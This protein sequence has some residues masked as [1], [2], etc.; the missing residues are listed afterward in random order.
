MFRSSSLIF[1][2]S[3]ITVCVAVGS[4]GTAGVGSCDGGHLNMVLA[5]AAVAVV[6]VG[7]GGGVVVVV[8][9]AGVRGLSWAV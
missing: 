9:V 1:M 7:G 3:R 2:I 5:V 6:A 4:L 8:V